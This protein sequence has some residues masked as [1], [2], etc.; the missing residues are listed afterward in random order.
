MWTTNGCDEVVVLEEAGEA[1]V[2][3]NRDCGSEE[4][5]V[6]EN[7]AQEL[8]DALTYEFWWARAVLIRCGIQQS[9]DCRWEIFS[10]WPLSSSSWGFRL[11]GFTLSSCSIVDNC[12]SVVL[13]LTDGLYKSKFV[14]M[15]DRE[16]LQLT[17]SIYSILRT[18]YRWDRCSHWICR[19]QGQVWRVLP[20][21]CCRS[22]LGVFR[23]RVGGCPKDQDGLWSW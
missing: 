21:C 8:K 16:T 10:G 6:Q 23:S 17:D 14:K 12:I 5:S 7:V 18:L 3:L 15:W 22:L 19:S 20:S 11:Q 13:L 9:Q 4:G 1:K 2:L